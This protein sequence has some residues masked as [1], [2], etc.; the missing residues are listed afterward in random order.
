METPVVPTIH[1][2]FHGESYGEFCHLCLES[3]I[4]GMEN[5]VRDVA[6]GYEFFMQT[7]EDSVQEIVTN[8][9]ARVM[10]S[11][12]MRVKLENFLALRKELK[13]SRKGHGNDASS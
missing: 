1:C 5:I 10:L 2:K 11:E 9:M 8:T 6:K 7:L 3:R 13:E 12:A 4:A